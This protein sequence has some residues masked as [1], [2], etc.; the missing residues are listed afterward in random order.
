MNSSKLSESEFKQALTEID[1]WALV[2]DKICRDF[3]FKDFINAFAFMT[4]MAL[5]SESMDHHPNWTNEF[6]KISVALTT[7]SAKGVTDKD[8]DWAA[9]ANLVY[10][11]Q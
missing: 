1:S 11:G 2:G 3:E 5:T 9:A 10:A 7:H 8:L 6:N 4:K